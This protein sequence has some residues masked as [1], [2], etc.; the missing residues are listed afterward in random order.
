MNTNKETHTMNTNKE[1]HIQGYWIRYAEFSGCW[2]IWGSPC[3]TP[4]FKTHAQAIVY[5]AC[6]L[7][8]KGN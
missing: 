1:I 8:P 2:D 7:P 5:A 3:G 6:S 4:R